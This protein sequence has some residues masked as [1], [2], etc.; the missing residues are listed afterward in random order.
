MSIRG[1]LIETLVHMPPM[2]ILD[3]LS[4]EQAVRVP[5]AGLHD[6]AALVAHMEFWQSWFLERCEGNAV[7]MA[8]SA[9]D[10]WPAVT[11]DQWP[12][13]VSRFESGLARAAALGDE[14]DR[15]NRQVTP[16]IEFPPLAAYTVR[17]ALTHMAQHNSHHLG[18]IVT[19]RQILGC[20]PPAAGS[21]TW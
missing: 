16:A 8:T 4:G 11:A 13:L 9:A 10:G 2:Q 1:Q 21:F 20:W 7:A 14:R 19:A 18:Q 17:E 15:L 5:F 3:G 6:I 12:D